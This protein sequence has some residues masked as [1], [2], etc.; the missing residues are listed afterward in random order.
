MG[1]QF[2]ASKGRPPK[3]IGCAERTQAIASQGSRTEREEQ[4]ARLPHTDFPLR[5]MNKWLMPANQ[6]AVTLHLRTDM[7]AE[8]EAS[9]I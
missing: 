5:N 2:S 7:K 8:H 1:F 9:S 4:K 6:V 3:G